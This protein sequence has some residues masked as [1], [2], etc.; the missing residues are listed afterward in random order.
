VS[1][2][3]AGYIHVFVNVPIDLIV[4]GVVLAM[5][6]ITAWGILESV[7]F[8]GLMTVIEVAGL[9]MIVFVGAANVPD[10]ALRLPEAWGGLGGAA[11]WSGILSAVL[12]AFFAFTGFEGLANIAEEVKE[13]ARTLPRAIFLTLGLVTLLYVVVVWIALIAVPRAELAA[14]KAPLSLVFER[15]TGASPAVITAI[16]IVATINGVVVFMVMGSRVLYGMAALGLL[17]A[18][19]ARVNAKTRTPLCATG[20]VVALALMLALTFPIEGLAE[21]VS[22]LTLIIFAFVNAALIKLKL[23]RVPAP[24]G[25]F[26]VSTWVPVVGLITSVALLLSELL[27]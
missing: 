3:C 15:A 12:L 7:A 13:P 24:S 10:L 17:P 4:V 9:L 5:G 23:D 16:S 8:A 27:R 26:V 25:A 14:T 11:A 2:G 22:R 18:A 1:R 20:V 6:V 19:L 21:M